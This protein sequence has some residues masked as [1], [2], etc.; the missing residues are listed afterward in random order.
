MEETEEIQE[1]AEVQESR[2]GIF[3]KLNVVIFL[4]VVLTGEAL[5]A[6]YFVP[7]AHEVAM[8]QSSFVSENGDEEAISAEISELDGIGNEEL[9]E[10]D[11]ENFSLAVPNVTSGTAWR[12]DFHLWGIIHQDHDSEFKMLFE[13]HR[14]RI[15]DQIRAII[16]RSETADLAEAGLGLIKRK[17]SARVNRTFGKSLL[18]GVVFSEFFPYEQ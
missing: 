14:H 13:R 4:I 5:I 18:R 12:V 8:A 16:L 6:Y 1:V 3:S 10:I 11:M 9:K 2:R 15:R 7:T 17:I